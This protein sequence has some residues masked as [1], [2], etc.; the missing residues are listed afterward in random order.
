MNMICLPV[1]TYQQEPSCWASKYMANTERHVRTM[2][3]M[4]EPLLWTDLLLNSMYEW[5]VVFTDFL[6]LAIL[7]E[8]SRPVIWDMH[9]LSAFIHRGNNLMKI[10]N[11]NKL[12]FRDLIF[13]STS[14]CHPN[15]LRGST[16][17]CLRVFMQPSVQG[18]IL[19]STWQSNVTYCII[20]YIIYIIFSR[21]YLWLSYP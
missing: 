14:L 11:K 8:W 1:D 19:C 18:K 15:L 3:L 5:L 9:R 20:I 2:D 12:F 16:F 13:S 4:Q 17:Y 6:T 7:S 21:S 10:N